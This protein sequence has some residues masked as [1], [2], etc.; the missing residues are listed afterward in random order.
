M[1]AAGDGPAEDVAEAP[2]AVLIITLFGR[3]S[4][5]IADRAVAF[6]RRRDQNVLIYVALAPGA[7]VSRAEL[8]AAF[9][10]DAMPAAASQGL[11]TALFRLRRAIA[12]AAG[13]TADR[14]LRVNH[15]VAL[16][17]TGV[18]IDARSFRDCI[19]LAGSDDA[20]GD[21]LG[22]RAKYLL[23]RRLHAGELLASE[24]AV[25]QLASRAA[26]YDRLFSVVLG[27]LAASRN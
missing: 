6:E 1:Y 15:S 27:R 7:I 24:A 21:H 22:A 12:G 5:R 19:A 20:G 2:A 25:P 11:R 26:E 14:Y 18:S 16:D 23:A 10:P 13:C 3:L 4:C 17:P 9:W 8:S